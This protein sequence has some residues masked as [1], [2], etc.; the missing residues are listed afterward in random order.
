MKKSISYQLV[1]GYARAILL[2]VIIATLY[3]DAFTTAS[4][5]ELSLNLAAG[6]LVAIAWKY[7]IEKGKK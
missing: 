2:C 7:T 3:L 5:S 6:S 4:N 1:I